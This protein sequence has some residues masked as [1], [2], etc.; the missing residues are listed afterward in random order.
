MALP[1]LQLLVELLAVRNALSSLRRL[2]GDRHRSGGP[3]LAGARCEALHIRAQVHALLAGGGAPGGQPA[4]MDA[5]AQRL[6]KRGIERQTARG[7]GTALE[8]SGGEVAGPWVKVRRVFALT[9]SQVAVAAHAVAPVEFLAPFHVS[10]EVADV[11][12]LGEAERAEQRGQQ[13]GS[14]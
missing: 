10:G 6:D 12:F 13:N 8:N 9:V 5:A 14:E 1:A 7:R 3:F 4:G 11:C 2:W